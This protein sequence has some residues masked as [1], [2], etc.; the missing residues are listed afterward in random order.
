MALHSNKVR[1]YRGVRP[2][3]SHATRLISKESVLVRNG[4]RGLDRSARQQ[5]PEIIRKLWSAIATSMACVNLV[6][7]AVFCIAI[8]IAIAGQNCSAQELPS[9]PEAHILSL[10]PH[11]E[12]ALSRP[13]KPDS[14]ASPLPAYAA[15]Y[16]AVRPITLPRIADSKFFLMNGLHLGMAVLDV[17]LT[18][19]CIASHQ[20][21]EGNPVMPSSQAGQLSIGI[22]FATLGSFTSYWLKRHKSSYWWLPPAGGI[23]GHAVGIATGLSH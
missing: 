7:V 14:N 22:G 9:A 17:E 20:C 11:E 21:R 2:D 1:L 8:N 23:A 3:S 18:Q 15:V 4:R 19:R 13:G 10:Q 6:S 12:K 5:K 16:N